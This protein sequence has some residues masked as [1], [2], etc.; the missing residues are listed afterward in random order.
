[1][2]ELKVRQDLDYGSYQ[3]AEGEFLWDGADGL[4]GHNKNYEVRDVT[5]DKDGHVTVFFVEESPE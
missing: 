3:T 1:M 5:R 4:I 2:K